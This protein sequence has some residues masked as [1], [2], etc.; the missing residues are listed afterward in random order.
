[1]VIDIMAHLPTKKY[2]YIRQTRDT[3][4]AI[5]A[6]VMTE[7]QNDMRR[8]LDRGKDLMSLLLRANA[9]EDKHRRMS[10]EEITAGIK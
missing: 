4:T 8:G 10:G 1:M 6:K 9:G 2:K 5:A 7:K 3:I